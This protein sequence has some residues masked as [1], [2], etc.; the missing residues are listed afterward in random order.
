MESQ[1]KHQQLPQQIKSQIPQNSLLK[2]LYLQNSIKEKDLN[3]ILYDQESN[4]TAEERIKHIQDSVT[5]LPQSLLKNHIHIPINI[6]QIHQQ[7]KNSPN[8]VPKPKPILTEN[9][10]QSMNKIRNALTPLNGDIKF[11]SASSRLNQSFDAQYGQENAITHFSID[12]KKKKSTKELQMQTFYSKPP[13]S[14]ASRN[15]SS[16]QMRGRISGLSIQDYKLN[17]QQ[18]QNGYDISQQPNSKQQKQLDGHQTI[19]NAYFHNMSYTTRASTARSNTQRLNK[20]SNQDAPLLFKRRNRGL[21]QQSLDFYNCNSQQNSFSI[22][23]SIEYFSINNEKQSNQSELDNHTFTG[24]SH[25]ITP[26][27]V[28]ITPIINQ[29][30]RP[31]TSFQTQVLQSQLS[32]RA[33]TNLRQRKSDCLYYSNDNKPIDVKQMLSKTPNEQIENQELYVQNQGSQQFIEEDVIIDQ[34]QI[35]QETDKVIQSQDYQRQKKKNFERRNG[36]LNMKKINLNVQYMNKF[37]SEFLPPWIRKR[38]DFIKVYLQTQI[39]N[40]LIIP[41]I[42]LK[43][44]NDRYISDLNTLEEY[45]RKIK[46]L[47]DISSDLMKSICQNLKV[48]IYWEGEKIFSSGDEVKYMFVIFE[49][50]IE[51]VQDGKQIRLL[52]EEELYFRDAVIRETKV[53]NDFIALKQSIIIYLERKDYQEIILNQQ[54]RVLNNFKIDIRFQ[55]LFKDFPKET[56]TKLCD[57][58]QGR[59]YLKDEIIY[60]FQDNPNYF[61]IIYEGQI[62]CETVFYML[63]QNCW[64]KKNFQKIVDYDYHEYRTFSKTLKN[65][66]I[67][68]K[69]QFFGDQ[70]VIYEIGRMASTIAH[71]NCF[72]LSIT[73]KQFFQIFTYKEINMFIEY[74]QNAPIKL[75]KNLKSIQK[76]QKNKDARKRIMSALN[77]LYESAPSKD[78]VEKIEQKIKA[79]KQYIENKDFNQPEEN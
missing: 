62:R 11:T 74:R 1:K 64:P 2:K 61:Y 22:N 26:Y 79:F 4:A 28:D 6:I 40:K 33:S 39:S 31:F 14:Q 41:R 36:V 66:K 51:E 69:G 60:E 37:T 3:R 75:E 24:S 70:E 8:G 46:Q 56:L 21:K 13:L 77:I 73:K 44:I 30:N 38:A 32:L 72:L 25:P 7:K 65:E 52:Q 58:L 34:N 68:S 23:N 10:Q 47:Q 20:Q 43:E 15:E 54:E 9:M 71:T 29:Q 59:L 12:E 76:E 48:H 53:T 78:K 49:G 55:T 27:S 42:C 50:Q 16:Q 18:F 35:L 63:N 17:E 57:S 67:L 19:K 5:K 45:M